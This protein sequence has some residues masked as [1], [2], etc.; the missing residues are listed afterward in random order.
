MHTFRKYISNRGSALFMV[1]STMTALMIT[2]MAMYFTVL[3]SRSTTYTIFNQKQAYQSAASIYEMLRNDIAG[4]Q[5]GPLV[6]ALNDMEV[7]DI[8]IVDESNPKAPR[9]FEYTPGADDPTAELMGDIK[10][11]VSRLEDG[12]DSK[13]R[14]G[15]LFDFTITVSVDGV[16]D[17]VHNVMWIPYEDEGGEPGNPN[18]TVSPTFAATGYVPNDVYLDR[19]RFNSDVFFDNETTYFGAYDSSQLFV[20]GNI[21]CA[22]SVVVK[23]DK[24][25]FNDSG[26]STIFSVRNTLTIE[27]GNPMDGK[28]GDKIYVGGDMYLNRNIK[29]YSVFVNG[30]LHIGIENQNANFYVNGDIYIESNCNPSNNYWCNGTIYDPNGKIVSQGTWTD[31]AASDT[32]VPTLNEMLI[33]LDQRTQTNVYYKWIIDEDEIPEVRLDGTGNRKTLNISSTGENVNIVYGSAEWGKGCVIDDIVVNTNGYFFIIIDTGDNPDNVY[34]IRVKA[35]RTGKDGVKNLFSWTGERGDTVRPIILVKGRG[36]V[37]IDVPEKVIYQEVDKSALAHYNWWILCGGNLPT[38]QDGNHTTTWLSPD[39]L[40]PY[41]HSKCG[42]DCTDGCTFEVTESEE[43]CT[44]EVGGVVCGEKKLTV[45]CKKHRK[46]SNADGDYND[47]GDFINEVTYCPECEKTL[48]TDNYGEY[49]ICKDTVDKLKIDSTASGY[50]SKLNLDSAGN[51]IYP[52]TNIYLV[53]S[54]ESSDMRFGLKPDGGAVTYN[55]MIGYVYAPY[56]TYYA[57]GGDQGQV[58]IKYMGG[59]TVSDYNFFSESKFIMCKPDKNPMDLMGDD[60]F[61]HKITGNKDWKIELVTH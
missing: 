6:K 48:V 30:D 42:H 54:D 59:M 10:V 53:S 28:T 36:S 23:Q 16:T 56:V 55:A 34:T 18:P 33:D 47:P 13:G 4:N 21:N 20:N 37:V 8:N 35:N 51:V 43:T 9:V 7:T 26:L 11:E 3:A 31:K 14:M 5:F 58:S 24:A 52:H 44:R 2:C 46:D 45:S 40:L 57:A 41:V 60:S 29:N 12:L 25:W 1:I 49:N 32:N 50:M 17:T 27:Y 61:K 38:V 15:R 39:K 19:G 22:G